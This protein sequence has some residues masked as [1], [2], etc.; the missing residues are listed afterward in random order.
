MSQGGKANAVIPQKGFTFSRDG[1]KAMKNLQED[2]APLI[3]AAREEEYAASRQ[4][5]TITRPILIIDDDLTLLQMLAWTLEEAGYTV[6]AV[7]SGREALQWIQA[8]AAVDELPAVILLDLS[9]PGMNGAQ[10][11]EAIR[12]RWGGN[13]SPIIVI[14]AS[15]SAHL[16]ARELGAAC[17]LTKPFEVERLLTLVRQFAGER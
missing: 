5:R 8:A 2:Y 1:V 15:P 17:T 4:I 6:A 10:V 11:A 13:V 14:S 9:M 3:V 7:T 12:Q 16:A